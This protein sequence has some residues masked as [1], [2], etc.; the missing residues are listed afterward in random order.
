M[1]SNR[2]QVHIY[3]CMSMYIYIY[4]LTYLHLLTYMCVYLYVYIVPVSGPATQVSQ[5]KEPPKNLLQEGPQG[6]EEDVQVP[7]DR[8]EVPGAVAEQRGRKAWVAV[9]EVKLRYHN[10]E[11]ILFILYIQDTVI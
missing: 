5:H 3:I 9:K 11:T 10:S 6:A 4:V 7:E 1:R 8:A 2:P